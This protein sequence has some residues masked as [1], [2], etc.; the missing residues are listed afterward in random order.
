MGRR[1]A[2]PGR[3][4]PPPGARRPADN[5]DQAIAA[6]QE[7]LQVLSPEQALGPWVDVQLNLALAYVERPRGHRDHNLERAIEACQLVLEFVSPKEMPV[8]WATAQ[9]ELGNAYSRRVQGDRAD[10]LEA[11][12]DAY[13]L[14]LR[15][16]TLEQ[17]PFQW[18][19]TMD[20]LGRLYRFRLNGDRAANL[21]RALAAHT[22]ALQ[23]RTPEET[24]IE[25][26]RSMRN[27][28]IAYRQ[29]LQGDPAENMEKA[30][31]AFQ[32]ALAV[33]ARE[34][35]P[36]HWAVTMSN[37]G[38]S[39]ADRIAGDPDENLEQAI[40][41]YE[42][43]L[44]ILSPET[45]PGPWHHTTRHLAES[46][47]AWEGG[48]RLENVE[49]AI[50]AYEALLQSQTWQADPKTT[51]DV[52]ADLAGARLERAQAGHLQDYEPA[53]EAYLSAAEV[54]NREDNP[55]TWGTIMHNLGLAFGS[56]PTGDLAESLEQA[57]AAY[58]AAL[59]V[60]TRDQV[61]AEW[62]DTLNN[63]GGIY[64]RRIHGDR[65][66]NLELALRAHATALE[67]RPRET[68]PLAWAQTMNNL[69]AVYLERLLGDEAE[70]V[71]HA[72]A[73]CRAALE[74]RTREAMPVQWAQTMN[75]LAATYLR[76]PLGERSENLEEAIVACKAVL[77]VRTREAMPQLWA[78]T[79]NNLAGAYLERIEGDRRENARH[80]AG[81]YRAVLAVRTREAMPVPWAR[82]MHNV[83][84]AYSTLSLEGEPAAFAQAVE[85]FGQAL[86]VRTLEVMPA[87]HLISQQKLGDLYFWAGQWTE[88]LGAYQSAL[89]AAERLYQASAT[90]AA[91]RAELGERGHLLARTVYCLAKVER[92]AEAVETL[93]RY[94]TQALSEAL[95]RDRA[96]LDLSP[97]AERGAFLAAAE[98]IAA[99]EAE[100]RAAG[101]AG[102]RDFVAVSADLRQARE[103]LQATVARIQAHVPGFLPR[104]LALAG[105]AAVAGD[106]GQPLVYLLTTSQG[107]LALIVRPGVEELSADQA[108]WLP[109]FR[110]ADLMDLLSDRDDE[111]HYLHGAAGSD[112]ETLVRV[113][114][115]AWPLLGEKLMGPLSERLDGW[116]YGQAVL[117][118]TGALALLPLPALA[119]D[120]V[121]LSVAPSARALRAALER[122]GMEAEKKD[123]E[124]AWE[125]VGLGGPGLGPRLL[126]VGNPL[127]N[128]QPLPFAALEVEAIAALF[129]KDDRH[130]LQ[131]KQALRASLLKALPGASYLHLACHGTFDLDDPLASALFLA[132]EDRLTLRD[133]LDGDLDLSAVR[134]AVL[135]ACQTGITDYQ[136]APD[137]ALGFP[138]GFLQ[139][140]VPGVV[141]T[142]WPVADIS[143]ALLLARFYELHLGGDQTPVEALRQ[144]Q[145]WLRGATAAELEL[146]EHYARRFQAS[147]RR[148]RQA[149]RLMRYYR[150]KLDA[151][152]FAHP[153]FWAA[154]VFTGV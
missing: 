111:W 127:P 89:S 50:D 84:L 125:C 41:A 60:R 139:A 35:R 131:E 108:L 75:N 74:V 146:G 62:A 132:G 137:E 25:W 20:S 83:A 88:A 57:L 34:D 109:N 73:A 5:L 6:Y 120:R 67:E 45:Q 72:L 14:A 43:A 80:A 8:Q 124:R 116:G 103:E 3:R 16:F 44:Q 105:V 143:S 153:F 92:Y 78:E 97:P 65:A 71:E 39:Y 134:L 128:P 119:L 46:Y 99:L 10:N 136:N 113:L 68:A 117:I 154:F 95:D 81:A 149:A 56:R 152:P 32:A 1:N 76:R 55:A 112:A 48:Q 24:P 52:L 53:I 102:G 54:I 101:S 110:T 77:Q 15:I 148:D 135:S 37:L 106:A 145:L 69:A 26:A 121:A 7:A 94:R 36:H 98:R 13:R 87:A 122:R 38:D 66:E 104:G 30:I 151:K 28:A 147:R 9:H 58:N 64:M 31:A 118:P 59:E 2:V 79:T 140:G 100:A 11:A 115:E 17:M 114:D 22:V 86:G 70:N 150:A 12:I 49:R 85:A 133:L 144:A 27:L 93:E 126:A 47:L 23:V 51:G 138:A 82:T 91:R 29:R 96:R 129:P 33:Y 18:A 90:P 63:L 21:E 141:S 142:L 19:G 42:A 40:A 123:A 107:G 4:L 61:P 130:T